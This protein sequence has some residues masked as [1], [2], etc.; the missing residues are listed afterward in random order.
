MWWA[1]V[2]IIGLAL[3]VAESTQ[4]RVIQPGAKGPLET[5]LDK[6]SSA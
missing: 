3:S 1:D 5:V 2:A 4:G 6:A